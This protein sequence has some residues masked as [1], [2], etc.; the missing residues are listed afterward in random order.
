MIYRFEIGVGVGD[1]AQREGQ[2]VALI[3]SQHIIED[4]AALIVVGHAHT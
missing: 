2:D 1:V 3:S 4:F